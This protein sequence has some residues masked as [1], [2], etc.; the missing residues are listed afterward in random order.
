MFHICAII[1]RGYCSTIHPNNF[2][3][4]TNVNVLPVVESDDPPILTYERIMNAPSVEYG[5]VTANSTS[6]SHMSHAKIT[7]HSFKT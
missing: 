5:R 4:F 7:S 2:K 6:I 1:Y 3:S